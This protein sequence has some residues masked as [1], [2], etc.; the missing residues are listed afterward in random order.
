MNHRPGPERE[1]IF[2]TG[3]GALSFP[4]ESAY[5]PAIQ[6]PSADRAAF[7]RRT[8]SHLGG[9][10]LAFAGLVALLLHVIPRQQV[11]SLFGG[12]AWSLLFILVAFI[13]ASWL[14]QTWARSESSRA[15]Q[16]LGLGLYVVVEA[17]IFLPLLIILDVLTSEGQIAGTSGQLIATAGILTLSVFAGLTLT[18]FVTRKDFSFLAPILCVGAMLALGLIVAAVFLPVTLGLWFSFAMVALMAGFVLFETSQIMLHYR[19][20]Q[21][22][23]AALTLF[24]SAATMFFYMLRLLMLLLASRD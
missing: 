6:A 3:A 7:L 17:I 10:I 1:R 22:V 18:V 12:S 2:G 21:H 15:V 23:A 8:Y 13:A 5:G 20:D 16:Y 24:A 19:T 9:A 4:R 14:A 11:L